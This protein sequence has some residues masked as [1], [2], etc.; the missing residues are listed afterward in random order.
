MGKDVE[1]VVVT[2][3]PIDH[4]AVG[5]DAAW[6]FG[7]DAFCVMLPFGEP[8]GFVYEINFVGRRALAPIALERVYGAD[9]GHAY[10]VKLRS[11]YFGIGYERGRFATI[12]SMA[13]WL[14]ARLPGSTVYYGSD[15]GDYPL[16]PWRDQRDELRA[17]WLQVGM[18]AWYDDEFD[19]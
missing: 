4:V 13:S 11:R 7:P 3:E 1:M 6:A 5:V 12:D 14:E 16:E 2:P 8:R 9:S 17:R 10:E 19:G 18:R 15:D